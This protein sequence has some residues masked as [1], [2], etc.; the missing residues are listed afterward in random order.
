MALTKEQRRRLELMAS[1]SIVGADIRAALDAITE[2]TL[3]HKPKPKSKPARKRARRAKKI[4]KTAVSPLETE[5]RKYVSQEDIDE[6]HGV[7]EDI[8]RNGPRS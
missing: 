3:A 1:S 5:L 2:A 7:L 8:E 4:A 6:N